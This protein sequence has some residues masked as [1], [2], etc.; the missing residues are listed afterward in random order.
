MTHVGVAA[1]AN[2]KNITDLTIP[3]NVTEIGFNAF[4]G[5][6]NLKTVKLSNNIT[7]LN[8][9]VFNEC[10]SL[11]SVII[12]NGVKSIGKFAF[13]GCSSLGSINLPETLEEIGE[14]AFFGCS[15]L[16]QLFIPK[17]FVRFGKD[18][19]NT[20]WSFI[21]GCTS[22][23][24]IVVDED[25]PVFDSRDNCNAIIE[26]ASNTLVAGCITTKIPEGITVIGSW[27]FGGFHDLT[28]ITLPHS[29]NR[30]EQSAFNG[31]GLR[32]ITLPENVTYIGAYAFSSC[33]SLK[34]FYCCAEKVPEAESSAFG[35]TNLKEV[36]LH[37]PAASISAYQATEPWKNFKEIVALSAQDDQEEP[38]DYI[39][40]VDMGK[41]W[42]VVCTVVNPNSSCHFE[43]YGI[44][45]EIERDGKTYFRV[46]QSEDNLTVMHDAGLYRE[47][48]R[49][50]YKYDE[51]AGRDVMLYDF[52]LKEGDTFT[53]EMGVDNPV[54][55]K[56]LK[57]G[58]LD[59][60][61]II[62]SLN[63]S[64]DTLYRHRYLRTWTIGRD[65][66]SGKYDEIATWVECVGALENMFSPF[67]SGERY[68]LAYIDYR[69]DMGGENAYLPFSLC[70]IYDVRGQIHGSNMPTGEADN[71][72]NEDWRHR[73]TYELEGDRLHVY[74]KVFCCC[75]GSHYIYFFEEQTDD[76]LVHKLHF[77]IRNLADAM[78]CQAHHPTDFYVSGFDPN[79]N[80]I[81][82]DDQGVEHPVIN[83]TPQ[84]E[85]RPF[86]EEGKVW[87]VGISAGM[88]NNQVKRVKYYYF[89]GD[90][91]IDGKTCKQ[92]MC[93]QFVSPD[94]PD[95]ALITQYPLLNTVGA[96]YEEDKKV[97]IYNSTSKQ[98]KMMYDFSLDANDILH[99]LDKDGYPP[100]MIGPNQTGGLE[101]FKGVYR[102]IMMY[103]DERT[104][105]STFW[106]EGVGSID[107]P[108][109]NT[110][111][112]EKGIH[113]TFLMSCTIGDEIIYLNDRYEDGATPESMGAR[114]NRFDFTH[115]I[116]TKPKARKRSEEEPLLYGEYNDL[117]LD[118]NLNPLDD[119]YQV[120]ITDDSGK[121]VYEKSI[122][123]GSIVG[124]NIDISAYAKGRYTVTVE[125][126]NESFTGEFEAQ[127]TG[128]EAIKTNRED[129]RND[130]YNLH[131]QRLSSL[132]KGLNIVNGQKI[133][134][135]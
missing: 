86:V 7:S 65:N 121:V 69:S 84:N 131:G 55:C 132:Q 114:K 129:V 81:V 90:T 68:R 66:G 88:S 57:L 87:K 99:F 53:Y 41:Q 78:A 11:E 130:I 64:T 38:N 18:E 83:K 32:E 3:D 27:A 85:Y 8:Q 91:I 79:L 115:T 82:V 92:M 122:N 5:C 93:Q 89:D 107:G 128:I 59:D 30:I 71:I 73:L 44:S 117:K 94:Y 56:V 34:D 47:E 48:N 108:T 12:P 49:R 37:V 29:L 25:N 54:N 13:E 19:N 50:V 4:N 6:S 124:L 22:L 119:A 75:A 58:W 104:I 77:E 112:Y 33:N 80:Y 17:N 72:E 45:E 1:F 36:T 10:S 21:Y 97:Y 103:V 35:N 67:A 9:G 39:P 118:I 100:L 105:H 113:E 123:A 14:Q 63:N 98:F 134:V 40:F 120:R 96:W 95:Y 2:C 126:S 74:G 60:G 127:T 26:T 111:Y 110:Y 46:L 70:D 62:E 20:Y 42:N 101:G 31:S 23:T 15:S 116:K 109:A 133:Y 106:L 76:P 52:S 16:K 61:P 24:S 125:N 43:R 102:D 51:M 28:S 135:K